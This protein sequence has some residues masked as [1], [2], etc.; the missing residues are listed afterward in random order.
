MKSTLIA[1]TAVVTGSRAK[2]ITPLC[3]T[4]LTI[5]SRVRNYCLQGQI[6][7]TLPGV[8]AAFT[9]LGSVRVHAEGINLLLIV[10]IDDINYANPQTFNIRNTG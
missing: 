4:C 9:K 7:Q 6:R 5:S 1:A 8:E 2:I 10:S 3:L